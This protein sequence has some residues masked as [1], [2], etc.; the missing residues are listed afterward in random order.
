MQMIRHEDERIED[1]PRAPYGLF[2]RR[3]QSA[4]VV[5]IADDVLPG[6]A[7]R[8]HVVDRTGVLDS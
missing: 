3:E 7:A 5:V 8:H 2:Q 4:A 6:V 1:P